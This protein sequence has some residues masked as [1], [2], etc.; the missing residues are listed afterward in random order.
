MNKGGRDKVPG[1][2]PAMSPDPHA[3]WPGSGL[4][5][6]S[7]DAHGRLRPGPAYWQHWLRRPELALVPESCRAETALHRALMAEPVR[8]VAP[9]DLAA[10]VDPDVRENY[11]HFIALRDDATAAG[12]LEGWLRR[13]FNAEP[14]RAPPIFL[15]LVTQA[16]VQH[17]L[18]DE[19]DTLAWRAAELFFR[20]QRVS[21][22]Q[23]RVLAA[24]AETV[25]EQAQ[26]Q[27]LGELGRLMAQAQVPAKPLQLAVLG[28]DVSGR[29]DADSLRMPFRSSLLL[30]LTHQLTQEVGHGLQFK[31][32]NAR[33]GLK[34]LAALL[35][36]WVQHMIGVQVR[37]EPVHRI[38][39]AHWRWHV[40][41][42]AEA[43][44]LLN[45][46]Y[47]GA[48]V[49]D[50]R[51]ARLISLFRLEFAD[52]AE[53]RADV[54]GAPVYLGLMA[55]PDGQL[56]LKPQNLLLNLPLAKAS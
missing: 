49:D 12:S 20:P 36:R 40:G 24:D 8:P 43:T 23:G 11:G 3:R 56:R 26:S 35:Q 1:T 27:G 29:Y 55:R 15:D 51:R 6:L 30:D 53:M 50:E 9:A 42:D 7:P 28:P 41:L 52:P 2:M 48:T 32:A 17:L 46:L 31:L 16:I 33:S 13:V 14:V 22:D 4:A 47:A 5:H 45:D 18:G 39:D 19:T 44:A 54:A 21:F 34:P 38:D 10:I 37:I 25:V